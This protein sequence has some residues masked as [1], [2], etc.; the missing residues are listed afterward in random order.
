M[1]QKKVSFRILF[2]HCKLIRKSTMRKNEFPA[3]I[4]FRVTEADKK[5][6][7]E[8]VNEVDT[9]KSRFIREKIKR[10]LTTKKTVK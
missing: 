8:L 4:S 5:R 6:F 7:D 9:S 2:T 3:V 10:V 1:G